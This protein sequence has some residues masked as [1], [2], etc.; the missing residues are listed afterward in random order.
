MSFGFTKLE[1]K[2]RRFYNSRITLKVISSIIKVVNK[3][4]FRKFI[5]LPIM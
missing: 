5:A 1:K 3:I 2:S 4:E